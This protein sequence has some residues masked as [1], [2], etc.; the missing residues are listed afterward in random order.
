MAWTKEQEEAIEKTGTNII[1][2]AGAGSGKT[3]VLTERTIRKLI[4]GGDIN[5]CYNMNKFYFIK[6]SIKQECAQIIDNF[7]TMYGYKVNR[8]AFPN[9]NKRSNWDYMKCIDVNLEGD[10]PESD[11]DKIRNLFNNGCTFW[12][13]TTYYLDYSQT[14]SIR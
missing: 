2:S 9:I 7:F 3:A 1:V 8:L 11:L 13:T 5:T 14:N 10:I 12:H 4:N 6:M